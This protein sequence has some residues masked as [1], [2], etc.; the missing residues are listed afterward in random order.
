MIDED[1]CTH[2]Y[3]KVSEDDTHV[4]YHCGCGATKAVLK[5]S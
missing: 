2:V 1:G 3:V 5:K 4:Y